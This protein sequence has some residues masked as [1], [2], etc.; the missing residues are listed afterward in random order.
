M[1][2]LVFGMNVPL[3]GYVDHE[4]STPGPRLFRHFTEEARAQTGSLDGLTRGFYE[5]L[6]RVGRRLASALGSG[7]LGAR[8]CC[9]SASIARHSRS[10]ISTRPK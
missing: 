6:R 3:D 1:A 10:F 8:V 7:P 2:R 4:A 9:N 5:R